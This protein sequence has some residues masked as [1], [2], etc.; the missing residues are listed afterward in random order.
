M[1]NI[2][3]TVAVSLR[4]LQE[5]VREIERLSKQFNA[6]ID[7]ALADY[8]SVAGQ[9]KQTLILIVDN[10]SVATHIKLIAPDL[11]EALAKNA[12]E[13]HITAL[14]CKVKKLDDL[15]P[16]ERPKRKAQLSSVAAHHIHNAALGIKN[17]RLKAA[18]EK[19]SSNSN[20]T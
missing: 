12:P 14:K 10:A 4:H 20:N 19:L 9:K 13:L 16:S 3:H 2:D 6:L 15:P 7:P 1:D 11:I 17:E 8:I 5:Q 18:L